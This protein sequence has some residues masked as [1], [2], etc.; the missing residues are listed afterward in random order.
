MS[1]LM[2]SIS[3][4]DQRNMPL[5]QV[6]QFALMGERSAIQDIRDLGIDKVL[7]S[8]TYRICSRVRHLSYFT[9]YTDTVITYY[10]AQNSVQRGIDTVHINPVESDS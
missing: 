10:L 8:Y 5:S 4:D 9:A 3:K 1:K 7:Y 6:M 2:Q